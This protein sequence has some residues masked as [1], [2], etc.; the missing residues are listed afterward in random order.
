MTSR[1]R[2]YLL[3]VIIVFIILLIR[4]RRHCP[5]PKCRDLLEIV[6]CNVDKTVIID[7]YSSPTNGNDLQGYCI[8]REGQLCE[9]L[10]FPLKPNP[11]LNV[12]F[13]SSGADNHLPFTIPITLPTNSDF[14]LD[15]TSGNLFLKTMKCDVP[16]CFLC[17]TISDT[18]Y[19]K[20]CE[21][22]HCSA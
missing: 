5:L 4:Q 16:D 11:T 7:G 15:T 17:Y 9:P 20:V 1:L 22:E 3:I 13:Q 8:L 12:S 10:Q 18:W 19:A 2:F 14:V 21:P 6:G